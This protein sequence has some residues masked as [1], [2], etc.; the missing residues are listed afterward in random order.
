MK[1]LVIFMVFVA[2]VFVLGNIAF[3][4][5]VEAATFDEL[6]QWTAKKLSVVVDPAKSVP[7]VVKL[8]QKELQAL[9]PEFDSN[10]ILYGLY[11]PEKNTIYWTEGANDGVLVH[12]ITHYFQIKYKL[13]AVEEDY[14]KDCQ[15]VG[16]LISDDRAR[17]SKEFWEA[18]ALQIEYDYCQ[19]FISKCVY[20]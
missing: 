18:Y 17:P 12:E 2:L 8:S 7:E 4:F 14:I 11:D 5:E 10:K 9:H 16:G 19:E 15:L 3:S 6:F 20:L 13:A 1:K